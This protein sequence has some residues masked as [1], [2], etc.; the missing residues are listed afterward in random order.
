MPLGRTNLSLKHLRVSCLSHAITSS[1]NRICCWVGS[2]CARALDIQGQGCQYFV[3]TFYF[4]Q[5]TKSRSGR[6]ELVRVLRGIHFHAHA[7]PQR[8][9]ASDS[10]GFWQGSW[11]TAIAVSLSQTLPVLLTCFSVDLFH[12]PTE[13]RIDPKSFV[14]VLTDVEQDW[15][16]C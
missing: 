3:I 11:V 15:R 9:A 10:E 5:L 12:I 14:L 16:M 8:R 4:V 7:K 13:V 2:F 1:F 6:L